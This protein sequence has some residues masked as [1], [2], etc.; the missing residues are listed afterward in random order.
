MSYY[1]VAKGSFHQGNEQLFPTSKNFQCTAI[2]A[3]ALVWEALGL[4]FCTTAI[5]TILITGHRIYNT[6][7]DE[8]R[9]GGNR[10][11]SPD[12]LPTDL[13]IHE[14]SISV[15]ENSFVHDAL[16]LPTVGD[17]G[18]CILSLANVLEGL[19]AEDFENIGFLL[20][21]QTVTVAFWRSQEQLYLFDPHPVNEDRCENYSALTSLLLS[22]AALDGSVRQFTVSRLKV[23]LPA[24]S[25]GETV[26][27]I[28]PTF[29]I[30]PQTCDTMSKY[31]KGNDFEYP[32]LKESLK[33]ILERVIKHEAF[34]RPKKV[35][36]G[37]PRLLKPTRDEQ[38]REANRRYVQRN[39]KLS[40]DALRK[41]LEQHPEVNRDAVCRYSEQHP[42]INRDAVRRYSE[43][44]PEVHR[45]VVHCYDKE[46]ADARRKRLQGFRHINPKLAELCHLPIS[47][48]RIIVAHGPM[49]HWNGASLYNI[50]TYKLKKTCLWNDDVFI[51]PHCQ[52]PLFTEEEDRKNVTNLPPLNAPFYS[53]RR[54]LDR[55][56]AY[57]DLFALCAL[58]MSGLYRH[59]SGLSFFI[60]EGRMYHQVYNLDAPGQRF[61]TA[62]GDVQSVNRCRLYIDDGEERRNIAISRP[63]DVATVDEIKNYLDSL[64][65]YVHEFR[66]LT[67]EPLVNAHLE[68]Q[69]TSRAIHCN[70]LCDRQSGIEV[71]A[72]LSC[73][74]AVTEPR[75]HTVWKVGAGRPSTIDLF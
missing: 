24:L 74:D 40:C 34:G 75:R 70:V 50:N 23:Y 26:Q 65:P 36:C 56:R 7:R 51:C 58:E 31:N 28:S 39:P 64:N 55:A 57:N 45:E 14:Q 66:G 16:Y 60:I 10:Y 3:C 9:I 30:K 68:L 8:N 44:H 11:L 67:D 62:G 35:R 43:Q 63:L 4:K 20:T 38:V 12:E 59:P 22:N 42:E 71:H 27:T 17:M 19:M 1:C 69:I 21:G 48:T 37:R 41:Y 73:D 2:P 5:D 46:N 54:F 29:E 52:A 72:V 25:D 6:L 32:N 47:L 53:N 13:L 61:V 15:I 33:V 18:D 49:G